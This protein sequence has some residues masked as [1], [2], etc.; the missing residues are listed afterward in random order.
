M[1]ANLWETNSWTHFVI[2]IGNNGSNSIKVYKNGHDR[3]VRFVKLIDNFSSI[4][5]V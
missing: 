1:V 3:T 5:N 4:P 2:V